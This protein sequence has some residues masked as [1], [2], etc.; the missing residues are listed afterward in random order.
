MLWFSASA[1][2]DAD[3]KKPS[4]VVNNLR[5]ALT[6]SHFP[7]YEVFRDVLISEMFHAKKQIC[8]LAKRFEDRELAFVLLNASRRSLSTRVRVEPQR[9]GTGLASGR[10][11]RVL[12][13]LRSLGVT[14]S[15]QPLS[16]LNLPAPAVV[17]LDNRAWTISED[18][19]EVVARP[20]DVEAAPFT[21]AEVC[22]WAEAA[23]G[24][25]PATR[26]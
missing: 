24:A 25:K 2:A 18:L 9:S 7:S 14:V 12:D 20:V 1:L 5:F 4:P 11:G 6:G 23:A 8:I 21:S 3:T 16:K 15:E 17:A 26:R 13:D 10:L 19:S 22:G